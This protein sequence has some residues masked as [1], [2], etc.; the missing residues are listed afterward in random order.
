MTFQDVI[1][2]R[3]LVSLLSRAIAGSALP[4]SLIFAGASG[5]GKRLVAGAVAQAVNCLAPR[6]LPSPPSDRRTVIEYDAC[7]A[8]AAC[9][10]I[11]RGVHPDVVVIE[12]GENGSI[13]IDSIREL[14]DRVGYRPFEGR[15]RAVIIDDADALVAAAQNALLKTLE[16]PPSA[17]IFMLIT[18]R[19]DML[20]PTVRSRCPHLRFQ[21]LGPDAVAEAL[22]RRGTSDV[23]ARAIAATAEGS[24]G[25]ALEASGKDLVEA[26]EVAIRVLSLAAAVDDPHRR[27]EGAKDLLAKTGAGGKNDRDQLVTQLRVMASVL[28]DVELMATGADRAALANRDMEPA[29]ARLSGF[30]G[31]RGIR[32]FGCLDRAMV[33]LARNASVKI[34]AD[35]VA[36]NL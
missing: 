19:P 12:P 33:A 11:A 8:C 21:P 3:T 4:P 18:A 9:A 14:I 27:I 7:G 2:H 5:V 15:R 35:W 25:R 13:K 24:I 1:G 23:E 28:R 36:L 17:S 16:E 26:R 6:R 30:H 34:V 22:V 31:D 29:L 10:R 20:L 32:A